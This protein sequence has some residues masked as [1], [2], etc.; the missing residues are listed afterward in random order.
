MGQADKAREKALEILRRTEDGVF[1][2]V[3]LEQSRPEFNALDNAFIL[4]LVYGTLRNRALLDWVLN[5]LSERPVKKTDPWTRNILR[6]GVYQILFL[7]KVPAHAAVN[8]S[9]ELA[10]RLGGKQGYVNGLLRNVQRSRDTFAYPDTGDPGERLSILTSHPEWLVRRWVKRFGEQRAETLLRANNGQAPLTARTNSLKTS[11]EELT[12][13]L[14]ATGAETRETAYSP[15]GIDILS[16]PGLPTLPAFREGLF[17]VQDEAAQLISLMLTPQPGDVVLDACAAPGGKAAHL[18]EMM[19]DEGVIIA[20]DNDPKRI[21]MIR[22]NMQRMGI[23]IVSPLA[24]T[25]ARYK[26]KTFNRILIDA[27]CSGLGVLRRHPDARWHKSENTLKRHQALQRRILEN[28]SRLLRPGGALVY[29]TCTT[30]PEEN[31]DVISWFL[32]TGGREFV[33]D[34]PRP[35][36]PPQAARLVDENGFFRSF[37]GEPAMDGFFGARLVRKNA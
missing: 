30:E 12:A 34:D 4:E 35:F 3:L 33:I 9:T 8:T 10:K 7:D 17:M 29:A 24:G 26:E 16:S 27:P 32:A 21:P 5:R 25:A 23:S 36:L 6:L 20:L 31:E 37:P 18:A 14:R 15:L 13:S 2:G 19:L 1:A 22:E 28:C 11:R